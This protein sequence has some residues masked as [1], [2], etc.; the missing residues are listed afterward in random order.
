MNDE[1]QPKLLLAD[2]TSVRVKLF[3]NGIKDKTRTIAF[4]IDTNGFR[5]PNV[6]GLDLF[7]FN[8][9]PQTGEFLPMGINGTYY[10]EST[11][12]FPKYSI[13]KTKQM[14]LGENSLFCSAQIVMDGF[15]INY[16]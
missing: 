15:K 5:K 9:Y 6:V 1:S 4:G 16:H 11:K 8:L 12:S 3:E 10:D 13:E 2:S 14:C 7:A